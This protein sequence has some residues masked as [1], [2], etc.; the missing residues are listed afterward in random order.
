MILD[1]ATRTELENR[2]WDNEAKTWERPDINRETLKQLNR[3][4]TI[5]GAARLIVHTGCLAATAWLTIFAA[6][7]HLL[8]GVVPFLLF[9]FLFGFLNGMEHEM[10][11]KIVFS[12]RLDA[13]S[14]IF[15]FIIHVLFK[16]GTRNQRLC[17]RGVKV[18]PILKFFYA[19]LDEHV[20]HHLFPTVPSRNLAKLREA[21]DWPIPERRNVVQ[22]WRE[23]LAIGR[24]K[25][26]QPGDEFIPMPE[27]GPDRV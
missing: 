27:L 22:C 20:E 4:S 6:R 1:F 8:L 25:E 18:S 17:T 3:R 11:H 5:E 26:K 21:I 23:I 2:E 16:V 12:R 7:Y 14:D 15:Y 9:V 10:R 13:L 24:H 19:G